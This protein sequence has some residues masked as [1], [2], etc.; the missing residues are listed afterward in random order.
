LGPFVFTHVDIFY[1]KPAADDT[2]LAPGFY[3][4]HV[5]Y[6]QIDNIHNSVIK[7]WND[8]TMLTSPVSGDCEDGPGNYE[9]NSVVT[10]ANST[11][12]STSQE[13]SEYC[14]GAAH[15]IGWVKAK[16]LVLS[17]RIHEL[18]PADLFGTNTHWIPELQRLAW[19]VLRR[20]GW[21]PQEPGDRAELLNAVV[22]PTRWTLTPSGIQIYFGSYEG[23]CY[24][25]TPDPV[26]LPWNRLRPLLRM[27][28]VP[29]G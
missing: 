28:H 5:G 10:Y 8:L 19:E 29:T 24:A 17:P 6:P 7:G 15:G 26:I 16:N 12:I 18:K 23:G 4:Q 1:A 25:C 13:F 21:K 9:D 3:I 27:N 14:H 22:D 2:G 20:Q 11:L